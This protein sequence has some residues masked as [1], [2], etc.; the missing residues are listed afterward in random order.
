MSVTKTGQCA[1]GL[2][3]GFLAL[4]LVGC[5]SEA[6]AIRREMLAAAG[7]DRKEADTPDEIAI[8]RSMPQ[9][10]V[11][12]R[13]QDGE[14]CFVYADA[15]YCGCMYVGDEA[16]YR[17]YV[18]MVAE[19]RLVLKRVLRPDFSGFSRSIWGPWRPL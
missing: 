6:S 10:E 4:S 13:S 1:L 18:A 2:I 7:F 8:L 14:L 3:A 16:A 17:R 12:S 19:R 5:A 15:I 11:F 9:H